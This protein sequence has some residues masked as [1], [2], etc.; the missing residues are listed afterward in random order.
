VSSAVYAEPG[1]ILFARGGVLTALPFDAR[2]RRIT[3]DAVSLGEKV[4]RDASYYLAAFSVSRS[5]VVALRQALPFEDLAE[6]RW[7]DR[8]GAPLGKAGEARTYQGGVAPS[9]SG[10]LVA[11]G[12]VDTRT[13]NNDIWISDADGGNLRRLIATQEWEGHPVWSPDETRIA[14]TASSGSGASLRVHD[15]KGGETTVLVEPEG[16]TFV[17]PLSWSRQGDHLLFHRRA[18]RSQGDLYV[19]SFASKTAT[20]FIETPADE[21]IGM[22]SPD[23]QWVA[24][25]AVEAG[26]T[27]EVWG[28]R[29]PGRSGRQR[30]A[31]DFFPLSWGAGGRE[32]VGISS[33]GVLVAI[34][35]TSS[36]AGIS[37]G[38]PK[39]L[40]EPPH[41]FGSRFAPVADHSRFLA[42][43]RLD[44]ERGVAEIR[45]VTGLIDR[46][47]ER[48][49]RGQ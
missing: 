15:V 40:I 9:P 49:G 3:G 44:P 45:L 2:A 42:G 10:R 39:V 47:R 11:F 34:P 31:T 46:L 19:W 21:S 18:E 23:G 28:T 24:F 27:P 1:F 37:A 26:G 38:A 20:A 29:F 17:Q 43:A 14:Y 6:P 7:I 36:A 8:Q 4:T 25:V 5:G 13:G 30:L 41:I 33:G 32:L 16:Q 12:I 48:S 22:F 35:I